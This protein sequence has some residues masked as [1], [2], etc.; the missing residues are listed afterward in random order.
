[1][2]QLRE[3]VLATNINSVLATARTQNQSV[4]SAAAAVLQQAHEYEHQRVV[5][6]QC[7]N[8]ASS[9]QAVKA[10]LEN[11]TYSFA[12]NDVT[13]ECATSYVMAYYAAIGAK[14]IAI[15]LAC[16]ANGGESSRSSNTP[17]STG[18][19]TSSARSPSNSYSS[20][21]T[22]SPEPQVSQAIAPQMRAVKKAID[23]GDLDAALTELDDAQYA[24]GE[25]SDYDR[26]AIDQYRAYVYLKQNK[27]DAAAPLQEKALKSPYL[28]QKQKGET[29][30]ALVNVFSEQQKYSEVELYGKQLIKFG[31]A[32]STA[33]MLIGQAQYF[34]HHYKD[35]I[36]TLEPFVS[37][38]SRPAESAM[39]IL[40]Y[41]YLGV[42]PQQVPEALR[43]ARRLAASYPTEQNK[44]AQTDIE[45]QFSTRESSK[46]KAGLATLLPPDNTRHG[47]SAKPELFSIAG[48]YQFRTSPDWIQI[49]S[50]GTLYRCDNYGT[51]TSSTGTFIAPNSLVWRANWATNTFTSNAETILVKTR[52]GHLEYHRATAPLDR[53]CLPVQE[54]SSSEI[55]PLY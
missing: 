54:R 1:L 47:D 46:Q 30:D 8:V 45:G 5:A 24:P 49:N 22:S 34:Q 41:C 27:F 6:A 7:L 9:P 53:A 21:S 37:S 2:A 32:G 10:Q 31:G 16:F 55:R 51:V 14:E 40:L 25:R 23:A 3:S 52:N 29:L 11:G 36:Q 20:P 39:Q 28:P 42:E 18:T 44:K 35:A 26:F 4:S 17:N 12:R 50:D 13:S 38:H 48:L 33:I 19:S 15:D 43:L